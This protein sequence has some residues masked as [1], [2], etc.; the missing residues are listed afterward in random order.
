MPLHMNDVQ[1]VPYDVSWQYAYA[2]LTFIIPI[3]KINL[4]L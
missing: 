1:S 4:A 3:V 2:S